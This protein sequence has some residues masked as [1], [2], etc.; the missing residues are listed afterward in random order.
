VFPPF[1]LDKKKNRV[2]FEH[3][4]GERLREKVSASNSRTGDSPL[5]RLSCRLER[6][7]LAHG[8]ALPFGVRELAVLEKPGAP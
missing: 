7:L 8:V 3:L 6:W 2:M 5:G 1:W 4:E